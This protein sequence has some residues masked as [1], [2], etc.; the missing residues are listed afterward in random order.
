[1]H[2]QSFLMLMPM[3]ALLVWAA[4]EDHR[5]RKIRNWLT[6]SMA[7]GGLVQPFCGG[8]GISFGMSVL[9]L[10]TGFGLLFLLFAIGAVG[11]GDVKLLA[12]IGAWVGP[13]GVLQIF[14]AEAVVGAGIVLYQAA[15]QGR[16]TLLTRNSAVVAINLLHI[17]QVG[18]DHAIETGKAARTV[19]RP[20]PFAVPVLIAVVALIVAG[21]LPVG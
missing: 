21:R 20:L 1:M 16:L 15:R 3:L 11:G 19:D 14:L 4:I 18:V 17:R 13:W 7:L 2:A 9:G 6:L 5:V 10:L 12:A 8:A